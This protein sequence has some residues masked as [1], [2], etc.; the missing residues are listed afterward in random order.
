M[1]AELWRDA[2][3]WV[4][5]Y[6]SYHPDPLLDWNTKNLNRVSQKQFFP[7]RAGN[8][9][10]NLAIENKENLQISLEKHRGNVQKHPKKSIKQQRKKSGKKQ[11]KCA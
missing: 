8:I 4:L 11:I 5:Q 1:Y 6:L 7:G 2:Q 10:E 3:V 9:Q